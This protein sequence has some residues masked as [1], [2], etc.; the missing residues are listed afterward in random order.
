MVSAPLLN[1]GV[2]VDLPKTDAAASPEEEKPVAVTIAAD[3]ELHLQEA[4][5]TLDGLVP[6]LQAL[7]ASPDKPVFVRAD[8]RAPYEVVAKVM[9]RLA[10]SGFTKLNLLTDTQ[11]SAPASRRVG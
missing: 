6:A 7:A 3:G 11:T 10:T 4:A 9:A 2:P 5:T 8:G 1:V